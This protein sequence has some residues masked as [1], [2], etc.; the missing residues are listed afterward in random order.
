MLKGWMERMEEVV[1]LIT[2]PNRFPGGQSHYPALSVKLGQTV[3]QLVSLG[4]AFDFPHH[5]LWVHCHNAQLM[6]VAFVRGQLH[7]QCNPQT[8]SNPVK[9]GQSEKRV[10]TVKPQCA[11]RRL[12]VT[13]K[14]PKDPLSKLALLIYREG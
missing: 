6:V 14:Y 7:P 4:P 3:L 2:W 1:I 10:L 8:P 9:P 12:Q 13:R 5:I 11:S